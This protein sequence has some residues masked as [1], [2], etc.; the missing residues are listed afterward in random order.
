MRRRDSLLLAGATVAALDLLRDHIDLAGRVDAARAAGRIDTEAVDGLAYLMLGY[1]QVYRSAG[2]ASLL[3]PVCGT[4]NLLTELAPG[5]GSH[6]DK[7]VSLIGQAGSLIGTI[8][9]FDLGDFVSA[10]RYL[11]IGAR[12]AQQAGDT[13]LVAITLGCRAFNATY[14]G[15]P[16]TGLE[17]AQGAMDV[18]ARGIHPRS[19]GWVAAVASEMHATL[20]PREQTACMRALETARR[21][22]AEPMPPVAWEGIGAFDDGKLRAYR[23]GDLLRLGRHSEAQAE[24]RAALDQLGPG[25][26]KHR[27]TAHIDLAD[28]YAQD[29][30]PDRSA[31]HASSALQIVTRTRHA[32]SLRRVEAVY[33]AIRKSGSAGVRELGS[34]LLEFRAAS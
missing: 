7:M 5:A 21:Q 27:C 8:F 15:D 22:L 14:G 4:L 3:G 13:E 31:A 23:G 16:V 20:G 28:A 10:R 30:Q 9:M 6:R 25:L 17:F 11:A 34:K 12:A 1:R 18:A 33:A 2:A 26:V 19:Y 32:E 24:L 29:D